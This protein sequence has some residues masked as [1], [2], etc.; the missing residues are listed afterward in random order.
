MNLVNLK[1]I[2]SQCLASFNGWKEYVCLI[3]P[4]QNMTKAHIQTVLGKMHS[5]ITE[6]HFDPTNRYSDGERKTYI[7]ASTYIFI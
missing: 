1:G 2:K 3:T 5:E 6:G 7:P 4:Q